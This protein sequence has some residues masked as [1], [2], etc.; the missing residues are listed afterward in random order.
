MVLARK[1][2][3]GSEYYPH[4][5]TTITIEQPKQKP[6]STSFWLFRVA[7]GIGLIIMMFLTGLGLVAQNAV[8]NHLGYEI[9]KYRQEITA[10]DVHNEKLKLE[11]SALSSLDRVE[12]LAT[13]Q[14]GMVQPNN[15]QYIIQ[16]FNKPENN[17][18]QIA[19]FHW[20]PLAETEN[21]VPQNTWLGVI[22]EFIFNGIKGLE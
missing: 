17:F 6:I 16:D 7:P 2:A 15:I 1:K 8:I 11:V 20:L 12:K 3:V 22:N 10:L 9:T 13:T 14:L 5:D 21:K 19:G 18:I 4:N